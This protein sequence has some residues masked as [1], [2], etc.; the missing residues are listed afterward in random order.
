MEK[1]LLIIC[2]TVITVSLSGCG[3]FGSDKKESLPP[4]PPVQQQPATPAPNTTQQQPSV[5]Q[6]QPSNNSNSQNNNEPKKFDTKTDTTRKT[7]HY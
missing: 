3:L 2:L 5:N 6:S 7:D 4:T 1:S